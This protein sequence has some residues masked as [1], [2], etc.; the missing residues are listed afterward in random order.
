[1]Q[2]FNDIWNVVKLFFQGL[3]QYGS[4]LYL[5]KTA[6]CSAIQEWPYILICLLPLVWHLSFCLCGCQRALRFLSCIETLQVLWAFAFSVIDWVYLHWF[7]MWQ[8]ANKQLSTRS[9]HH[10]SCNSNESSLTMTPS[11]CTLAVSTGSVEC[12]ST[13]LGSCQLDWW[14]LIAGM[15]LSASN[16]AGIVK[17]DASPLSRSSCHFSVAG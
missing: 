8:K 11:P 13:V 14:A 9:R 3:C 2:Q 1:M 12:M 5:K 4:L 17:L 7:Q 10:F 6:K 16:Y 15:Q